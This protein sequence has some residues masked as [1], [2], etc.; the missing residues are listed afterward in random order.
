MYAS[1]SFLIL[2]VQP[3]GTVKYKDGDSAFLIE[4]FSPTREVQSLSEWIGTYH[5]RHPQEGRSQLF[6]VDTN[7]HFVTVLGTTLRGDT[8]PS[9]IV[10]NTTGTN[11]L[12]NPMI[13][14]LVDGIN[15]TL[16]TSIPSDRHAGETNGDV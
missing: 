7:G 2:Q 8:K 14:A 11:F 3:D 10:F 16:L 6:A 5:H 1:I 15:T 13:Q 4:H 12:E 9:V